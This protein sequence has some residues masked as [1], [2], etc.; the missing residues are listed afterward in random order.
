MIDLDGRVV[1]V[2]GAAQGLGRAHAEYLGRRGASVV[3]N[4]LQAIDDV[5]A[6]ISAGAGDAVGCRGSIVDPSVADSIIG[7]AIERYGRVHAVVCNAGSPAPGTFAGTTLGQLRTAFDV[8]VGGSFNLLKAAAPHFRSQKHGRAVL[9]TSSAGLIGNDFDGVAYAVAKAAVF[10]LTRAAAHAAA[11]W[12]VAVN[13]IAPYARTPS[14][15]DHI[16]ARL[17]PWLEPSYISPVVG[18]LVSDDC[19][20]TGQVF[21]C[22]GGAVANMFVGVTR[23]VR[24]ENPAELSPESVRDSLDEIAAL[25]GFV[26]PTTTME[27]FLV[28]FGRPAVTREDGI[29]GVLGSAPTEPGE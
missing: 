22:A 3:V 7:A 6:T 17:A 1:V 26:I 20:V 11:P 28:V 13:A 25:Q 19:N 12:G 23:G 15:E 5:V 8:H 24:A 4:D 14:T 29:G 2:T 16:D 9:T 21:S 18:W 10:G 27:D